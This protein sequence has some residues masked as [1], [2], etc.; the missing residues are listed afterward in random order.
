MK[1]LLALCATVFT[2]SSL[3]AQTIDITPLRRQLETSPILAKH[4]F[5][6]CLYDLDSNRFLLGINEEKYFTPASNAKIF[7]LHTALQSL[8]DSI[9]GLHYI[10]RGDSLI[11]WGTGDPTF[12]HNRLDSKRVYQ[13]LKNSDKKLFYAPSKQM[14]EA[15]YRKGWAIE[16]YDEYYQPEL[17][18]FPIYGNVVTFRERNGQL[19]CSPSYFQQAVETVYNGE[20]KFTLT[21]VFD[22]NWFT[23]SA[24]R[25]PRHYVNEKPFRYSEELF[26]QLLQDTLRKNVTRINYSKPAN[27]K[28]VYSTSTKD[29][30]REMML[31]SDNFLAEQ[32]QLMSALVRYGDFHT[33]RLRHEM[34]REFHRAF[35]DEITLVDGSGLS[36]YNKVTPRS[37]VEILLLIRAMIPDAAQLHRLFPTGGVD[38]TLKRAYA[39]DRGE[40]F[41]WAKT[42]TIHAVHNQSGFLLT[43]SGRNLAF[44]FLNTNF[45][46]SESSIRKEMVRIMTFIREHY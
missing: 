27:F 25:P 37:M 1:R 2:I 46:G 36:T 39:L 24:N 21:R 31:P 32:L 44:S 20:G 30:L 28:T 5:G 6:F 35:T 38:G 41:V 18:G 3:Y 26:V 19:E 7:T 29:V 23:K 10:E 9:I 43:R 34:Q 4:F 22:R 17:S 13:F 8:G 45:L 40:P 42:G 12:L 14:E 15:F 33:L 11:F 16:D